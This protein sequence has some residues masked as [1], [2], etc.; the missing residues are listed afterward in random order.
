MYTTYDICHWTAALFVRLFFNLYHHRYYQPLLPSTRDMSSPLFFYLIALILCPLA[1]LI[2]YLYWH[3]FIQ[4]ELHR[5]A[6]Q[7]SLT[8]IVDNMLAQVQVADHQSRQST[9]SGISVIIKTHY[10]LIMPSSSSTRPSSPVI[11]ALTYPPRVFQEAGRSSLHSE[12]VVRFLEWVLHF[13]V[14]FL[15]FHIKHIFLLINFLSSNRSTASD[16][17]Y[18]W[19]DYTWV[20]RDIIYTC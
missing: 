10:D 11:N 12:R 18:I 1:M 13:P 15:S 19:S 7:Q 5:R 2:L 14:C 4:Q 3:K 17:C 9:V 20:L 16:L 8:N 6:Q